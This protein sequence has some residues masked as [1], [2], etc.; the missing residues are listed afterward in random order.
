MISDLDDFDGSREYYADICIIGAGV[1]GVTIAREYLN[2]STS[3]FAGI[4][5]QER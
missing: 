3:P 2:T 1:A 4:R 5:W